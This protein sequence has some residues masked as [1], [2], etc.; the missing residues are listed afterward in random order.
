[1]SRAYHT[2][3][4]ALKRRFRKL[5]T[6]EEKQFLSLFG[7]TDLRNSYAQGTDGFF[8]HDP[9]LD[10]ISWTVPVS[11]PAPMNLDDFSIVP[12]TGYVQSNPVNQGIEEQIVPMIEKGDSSAKNTQEIA[13]ND[14]ELLVHMLEGMGHQIRQIKA[15]PAG[16]TKITLSDLMGTQ[17]VR[18]PEL[19]RAGGR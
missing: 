6:A 10:Q 9:V 14:V 4:N 17:G 11:L 15:L 7:A 16:G 13:Q 12:A 19:V 18:E 3:F 8:L 5:R 2:N 1:M